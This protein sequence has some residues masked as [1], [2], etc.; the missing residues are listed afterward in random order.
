MPDIFYHVKTVCYIFLRERM[1]VL[2]VCLVKISDM[3][4]AA[5]VGSCV[6]PSLYISMIEKRFYS[7]EAH[8]AVLERMGEAVK[9]SDWTM[10][11]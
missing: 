9:N 7:H 2:P 5:P 6:D 3:R 8:G 10:P 1:R 4:R 11:C